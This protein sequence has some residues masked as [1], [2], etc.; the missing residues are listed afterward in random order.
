MTHTTGHMMQSL[1]GFTSILRVFRRLFQMGCRSWI[2][3]IRIFQTFIHKSMLFADSPSEGARQEFQT[4]GGRMPNPVERHPAETAETNKSPSEF[5]Y[6]QTKG[7][8]KAVS[9]SQPLKTQ[10]KP[11]AKCPLWFGHVAVYVRI[12]RFSCVAAL[13]NSIG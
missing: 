4:G 8:I 11:N 12:E 2:S 5:L 7:V 6:G 3:E 9:A 10:T 1:Q 13:P